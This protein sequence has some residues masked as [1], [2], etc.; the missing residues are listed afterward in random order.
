MNEK[1]VVILVLALFVIFSVYS[2]YS[3]SDRINLAPTMYGEDY[4]FEFTAQEDDIPIGGDWDGDG[5]DEIGGI[6]NMK[7]F[8]FD[9]NNDFYFGFFDKELIILW[10]ASWNYPL[11][12]DWTPNDN[13]NKESIGIFDEDAFYGYAEWW[14]DTDFDG[15]DSTDTRIHSFASQLNDRPVIGDWNGDGKDDLGIVRNVNGVAMWLLDLND[16]Q[17]YDAGVDLQE[18]FGEGTDIPVVGNFD[19]DAKSEI[20]VFRNG[21]WYIDMDNDFTSSDLEFTF[22]QAGDIPLVANWDGEGADDVSVYVFADG[23]GSLYIDG[24]GDYLWGCEDSDLDGFCIPADCDDSDD[25][26]NPTAAENCGNNGDDDCDESIDC[27]DSDCDADI[28]CI[29]NVCLDAGN[30]CAN[31]TRGCGTFDKINLNCIYTDSICCEDLPS[32]GDDVCFSN[33]SSYYFENSTICSDDCGIIS[34]GLVCNDT[35][36]GIDY[37]TLGNATSK[38]SNGTMKDSKLDFC[39][40]RILTE[41]YCDLN[42]NLKVVNHTCVNQCDDGLC[43]SSSADTTGLTCAS[44]NCGEIYCGDGICNGGEICGESNLPPYCISDCGRCPIAGES[45]CGDNICDNDETAEDCPEDCTKS[46]SKNLIYFIVLILIIGIAIVGFLLYK[47]IKVSYKKNSKNIIGSNFPQKR[48]LPGPPGGVQPSPG[49]PP[50][51]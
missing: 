51:R 13:Q 20:G 48:S 19:S 18:A 36:G 10:G 21:D 27:D 32:C 31:V 14:L 40:G 43:E 37:F 30:K 9:L 8:N 15:L 49:F 29:G 17:Q 5:I 2:I 22:G 28:S 47:K 6:R 35:D 34:A 3:N 33:S 11:V 50:F 25:S 23:L 39:T 38:Y 45:S 4:L 12:G 26:I 7:F 41:Y 46:G 1:K 42:N 24:N 16:N 44:D